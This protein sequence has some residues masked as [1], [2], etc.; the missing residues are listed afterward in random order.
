MSR[1]WDARA[2]ELEPKEGHFCDYAAFLEWFDHKL[3]TGPWDC[4]RDTI[5]A[6]ECNG[7]IPIYSLFCD[8]YDQN[9]DKPLLVAHG[10]KP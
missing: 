10:D 6:V 1:P 8:A 5:E 9:A 7:M 4:L 3:S 2:I